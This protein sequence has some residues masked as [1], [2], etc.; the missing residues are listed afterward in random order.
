MPLDLQDLL[1]DVVDDEGDKDELARH[2]EVVRGVD[3]AQELD[4]A[5]VGVGEDAAGG[6]ELKCDPGNKIYFL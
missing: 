6:R 3:V 1:D 5:E 4:R 2:D